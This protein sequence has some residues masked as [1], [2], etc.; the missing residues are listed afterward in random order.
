MADIKIARQRRRREQLCDRDAGIQRHS[1]R[2]A[3]SSGRRFP[4][5]ARARMLRLTPTYRRCWSKVV[6]GG[7]G[8]MPPAHFSQSS[9]PLSGRYLSFA[10]REEIA[11]LR[12]QG[13]GV[14]TIAGQLNR[15]PCIVSRE[16]RRNAA[17]RSGA[18][19]YR[20]TS[21]RWHADRSARRRRLTRP[22][23]IMFKTGLPV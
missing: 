10:E 21:A 22:C 1:E 11:L 3:D 16:L 2:V 6:P 9:K 8:G 18:L 12:A 23:E 5:G 20:A 7:A 4:R 19:D 15:P 13:H 14:R 17:T